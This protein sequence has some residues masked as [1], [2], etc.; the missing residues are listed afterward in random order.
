MGVLGAAQVPHR[1]PWVQAPAE[2]CSSWGG[3]GHC[4]PLG[5]P[6][7]SCDSATAQLGGTQPW[8]NPAPQSQPCPWMGQPLLSRCHQ[9]LGCWV[10]GLGYSQKGLRQ[11]RA[12]SW[13]SNKP[14]REACWA[15]ML[16]PCRCSGRARFCALGT[17]HPLPL[18]FLAP[19]VPTSK[20]HQTGLCSRHCRMMMA[21]GSEERYPLALTWVAHCLAH[22]NLSKDPP[23]PL[24]SLLESDLPV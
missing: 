10:E 4:I 5:T 1:S 21:Q 9:L 6:H 18:M 7:R 17:L 13:F 15:E 16:H 23:S 11:L 12:R 8:G 22:P 20:S 19:M 24:R 3:S 2:A 14:H